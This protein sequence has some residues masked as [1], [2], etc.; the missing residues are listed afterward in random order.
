[1][2]E[3]FRDVLAGEKP[4]PVYLH[5]AVGCGKT[6][7]ALAVLDRVIGSRRYF[8][9]GD[10][11]D[12]AIKAAKGELY[13]GDYRVHEGEFWREWQQCVFTVMDE[14][15]TREKVPDWHYEIVY[16]AVNYRYGMPSI[17]ISNHSLDDLAGLYDERLASRLAEGT[18]IE[19][20]G[21]DRRL[22]R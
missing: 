7:A 12:R 19:I 2:H 1:M 22:Q 8:T 15:G 17:W 5:G 13:A 10:F 21:D 4:W 14:L 11:V 6:C 18:V 3:K 20:Q 9:A 16:K